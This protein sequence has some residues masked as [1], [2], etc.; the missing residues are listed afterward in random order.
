MRA[1]S[2]VQQPVG[3]QI[4]VEATC[5]V[6]RL[7]VCNGDEQSQQRAAEVAIH[8]LAQSPPTL[9][10]SLPSTLGNHPRLVRLARAYGVAQR[11]QICKDASPPVDGPHDALVIHEH[12]THAPGVL[13]DLIQPTAPSFAPSPK[14]PDDGVLKGHRIA[15]ITNIP[16]H[17]RVALFDRLASRLAKHGAALHVLFLSRVPQD[18]SWIKTPATG[19][20][21]EFLESVDV[22]RHRGRRLIPQSLPRALDHFAPTIVLS[23]GFSPFV[24]QRV[25]RWC[26][27]ETAFGIWSGEISSRPTARNAIRKIQRRRLVRRA[28]FAIAYGSA[29]A[30]YLRSLREDLPIVIGRNSTVGPGP[31]TRRN[32]TGPVELL[33]VSRAERGKALELIVDAMRS[34]RDLDCRLTLIGAGRASPALRA[35]SHGSRQVRFLGALSPDRV[36]EQ[37]RMAD[38]FLFPSQYDVFGL[39]LVEAMAAGLRG[40]FVREARRSCR[41]GCAGLELHDRG[42][43]IGGRM[44]SGNQARRRGSWPSAATRR[45]GPAHDRES[46]D[47][48]ARGRGDDRRVPSRRAVQVGGENGVTSFAEGAPDPARKPL[49]SEL[50]LVDSESVLTGAEDRFRASRP[51]PDTTAAC[52]RTGIVGL[53]GRKDRGR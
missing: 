42:G 21:H 52:G 15:V 34:L 17:Y 3:E 26:S 36:R 24:S 19:F 40:H 14:V 45:R 2:A 1:S 39:V 29:S 32:S 13:L 53:A 6:S 4:D 46:V 30:A 23:A 5:A 12:Q 41:S 7:V 31:S 8:L 22:G 49:S 16:I 35:R 47:A 28:D 33:A 25:A 18:R 44:G 50:V 43:A 27:D 48:R 38:V 9:T 37:Y 51:W 10:A 11:I 20:S